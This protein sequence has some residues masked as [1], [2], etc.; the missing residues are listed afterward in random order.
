LPFRRRRLRHHDEVCA[1]FAST[2]E[3]GGD[4]IRQL[5]SRPERNP[6]IRELARNARK[7]LET[8]FPQGLA[9]R[10]D[11]DCTRP[12]R[13]RTGQDGEEDD[14]A[15]APLRKA[16]DPLPNGWDG[17]FAI[18]AHKD[19]AGANPNRRKSLEP[20]GRRLRDCHLLN[21]LRRSI[22]GRW[23]AYG[24]VEATKGVS[25]WYDAMSIEPEG[26]YPSVVSA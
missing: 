21:P 11:H 10:I 13:V 6:G 15:A 17:G 19:L 7:A 25:V 1:L 3:G 5:Y 9:D 14:L 8:G 16:P 22:D 12:D 26:T 23:K 24:C 2:L 20:N 18:H 4:P